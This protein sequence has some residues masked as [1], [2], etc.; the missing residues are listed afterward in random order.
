M[1]HGKAH[2]FQPHSI[3]ANMSYPL[4][5][6]GSTK[7]N[8]Q[9][10]SPPSPVPA[11]LPAPL[12][13]LLHPCSP[14][15]AA[16]HPNGPRRYCRRIPD[17]WGRSTIP[18]RQYTIVPLLPPHR[19]LPCQARARAFPSAALYTPLTEAWNGSTSATAVSKGA[20]RKLSHAN[21]S[22]N[23][24]PPPPGSG[25]GSGASSHQHHL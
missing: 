14:A 2:Q 5:Y 19:S 10:P 24:R 11:T 4:G 8:P 3:N 7:P 21:R 17:P 12:R 18:V 9:H 13:L 23:R 15:A 22:G 25:L 1:L 6:R 20:A 16:T